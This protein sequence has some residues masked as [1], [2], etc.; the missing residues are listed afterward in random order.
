[1]S[2]ICNSMDCSPPGSSVH[3]IFQARILEQVAISY[4]RGS[5]PPRDRTCNS[6]VSFIGRHILYHWTTWEAL[7][8]V[9]ACVLGKLPQLRLT[10]CNPMDYSPPGSSC[11]WDSPAR[12]LAWVAMPFLTQGLNLHLLSLLHWQA[13]FF[14]PLAPPEKPWWLLLRSN[15]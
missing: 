15:Y 10:L 12:T 9:Y 13:G 8:T 1:M 6:C 5:S 3:V 7:M 14:L 2:T 11:P 4:S